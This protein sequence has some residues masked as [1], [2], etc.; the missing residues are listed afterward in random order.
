MKSNTEK[1]GGARVGA[2][3]KAVNAYDTKIMRIPA[4]LISTVDGV[5]RQYKASQGRHCP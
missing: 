4:P 5:I 1:W 3:R 2:G